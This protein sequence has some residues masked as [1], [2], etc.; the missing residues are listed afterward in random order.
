MRLPIVPARLPRP[1][2]TSENARLER[3][4]STGRLIAGDLLPNPQEYF[5]ILISPPAGGGIHFRSASSTGKSTALH[6]AGS[7]WGGGDAT[8]YV[9]SWRATANGLEGVALNHCDTLL[10]LDELSQLAAAWNGLQLALSNL[11]WQTSGMERATAEALWNAVRH[12]KTQHDILRA[13]VRNLPHFKS[14]R[15]A[16]ATEVEW[17]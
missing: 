2:V 17:I 15:P 6:V 14:T 8:G 13:V 4:A 12:D 7:V 1:A 11:F 3:P 5:G 10:C 9:R 16:L